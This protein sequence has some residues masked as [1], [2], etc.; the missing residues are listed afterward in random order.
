MIIA[1][2]GKQ[3]VGKTT[4]SD[5]LAA[6]GYRKVSFATPMRDTF[7]H[8]FNSTTFDREWMQA[9]GESCR[10]VKDD[11]WTDKANE[12]LEGYL[13]GN[14][15]LDDVRYTNEMMNTVLPYITRLGGVVVRLDAPELTRFM[16]RYQNAGIS[17]NTATAVKKAYG[18]KAPPSYAGSH[19]MFAAGA[20]G[21]TDEELERVFKW[22]EFQAHVSETDLDNFDF[23]PYP[24]LNYMKL[25]SDVPQSKS[26]IFQTVMN[27][28]EEV[29]QER[30]KLGR[31]V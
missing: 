26:D 21:V 30:N 22:T 18:S 5:S 2:T 10:Q 16:R 6:V 3:G 9:F 25:T 28:I 29:S 4:L 19:L 20:A 13:P 24:K 7:T 1:I 15:V 23:T 27:R 14:V 31:S 12:A 11:I 8:V 17:K